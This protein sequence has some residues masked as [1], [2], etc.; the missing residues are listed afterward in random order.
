MNKTNFRVT[1]PEPCHENWDAMTPREKGRFCDVCTK[2]VVDF[3]VMSDAELFETIKNGNGKIC[4]HFH[5]DQLDR[6]IKQPVKPKIWLQPFWKYFVGLFLFV[7]PATAKAQGKPVCTPVTQ[8]I[9]RIKMGIIAVNPRVKEEKIIKG[10]VTDAQNQPIAG[11]VVRVKGINRF[12]TSSR[13]GEFNIKARSSDILEFTD[14]QYDTYLYTIG[15]DSQVTVT[16]K[17]K[18]RQYLD[19]E[20]MVI[21]Q[22]VNNEFVPVPLQVIV[23]D[24]ETGEPVSDALVTWNENND[25]QSYRVENTNRKGVMN[26]KTTFHKA[27]VLFT[28]SAIGYNTKELVHNKFKLYDGKK[29]VLNIQLVKAK[30]VTNV[31]V[32][33]I[34]F[35]PVMPV[36]EKKEQTPV[37]QKKTGF[38]IFPNPA[39]ANSKITLKWTTD[40]A[41]TMMAQV[42]NAE[43]K[44]LL[45]QHF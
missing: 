37:L 26:T 22:P 32:G 34:A 36:P 2:T 15:K 11:V 33:A 24:K 25:D 28:V 27:S 6:T 3:S 20:V 4:G 5:K 14:I 23:T 31:V 21:S 44:I 42:I 40:K 43:G 13:N 18:E 19:G 8:D 30:P 39:G 45:N 29:V 17:E 9:P 38:S 7:K 12:T 35:E 16:L 41:E 10:K 1:I